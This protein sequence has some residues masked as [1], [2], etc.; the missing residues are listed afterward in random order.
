M[1]ATPVFALS[2]RQPWATLIL[3]GWKHVENRAW[4]T[5]HTGP[6]IIHAGKTVDGPAY[7]AVRRW[8][9]DLPIGAYLGTVTLTGCHDHGSPAGCRACRCDPKW[10]E[11]GVWHWCLTHPALWPTPVPGRGRQGLY[12]PPAELCTQEAS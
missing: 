8:G 7:T 9:W 6:L 5:R 4:G 3:T 12:T 10:A 11:D 1:L 2:V